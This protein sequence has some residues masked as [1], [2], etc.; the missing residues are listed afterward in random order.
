MI[1]VVFIDTPDDE[2][3]TFNLIEVKSFLF[4]GVKL[5]NNRVGFRATIIMRALEKQNEIWSFAKLK[6]VF[7]LQEAQ[8]VIGFS[9]FHNSCIIMFT[10]LNVRVFIRVFI[11]KNE[12]SF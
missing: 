5:Y 12:I 9:V 8:I 7:L 6:D 3:E 11:P 4:Y 10:L 1:L 2:Q